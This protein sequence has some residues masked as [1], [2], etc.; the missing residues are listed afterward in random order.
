MAFEDR[1][2]FIASDD[3]DYKSKVKAN[4]RSLLTAEEGGYVLIR[5]YSE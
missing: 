2:A 1:L 3:L 4:N 5:Y